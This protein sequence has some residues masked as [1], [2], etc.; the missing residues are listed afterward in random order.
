[1]M[2]FRSDQLENA[3]RNTFRGKNVNPYIADIRSRYIIPRGKEHIFK[4][5]VG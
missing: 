5:S 2:S 1:M 4:N 3:L